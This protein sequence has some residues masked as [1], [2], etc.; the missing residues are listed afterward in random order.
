MMSYDSVKDFEDY[1]NKVKMDGVIRK[2]LVDFRTITYFAPQL[3]GNN[4][5]VVTEGRVEGFV[6]DLHFYNISA[7]SEAG[8]FSGTVN[9]SMTG[10]PDINKTRLDA[11]IKNFNMTADGL[12]RF[13]SEWTPEGNEVDLS[14]FA[15]GTIF[16]VDGSAK[17]LLNKMNAK[18]S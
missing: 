8:G 11:T 12:G 6:S 9:G 17:G 3:A 5:R 1:I 13:V 16:M 7:R 4:L 2:S 10:L 15:K 18:I 14:R